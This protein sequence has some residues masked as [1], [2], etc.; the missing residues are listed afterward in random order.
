[1]NKAIKTILDKPLGGL[2]LMTILTIIWAVIG[3][4]NLK[5][6]DDY[7]FGVFFSLIA[8]FFSSLYLYFNRVSKAFPKI[9]IV[10]NPKKEKLYWIVFIA[11]GVAI[12]LVKN[13]LVNIHQDELFIPCLALI[14][15]VHFF[16]LAKVFDRKFDYFIGS[17][18]TLIAIIGIILSIKK[19][20]PQ[21]I[22]NAFICFSCGFA[23]TSYGLRMISEAKKLVAENE[24]ENASR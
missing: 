18:T 17:F 2:S 10:E 1:M 14:V 4:L 9:E 22:I 3:E 24:R 11:E 12:L 8:L 23:T 6:K 21:N 16:P 5:G 15:G 13:I 7:V 20:L 19:S